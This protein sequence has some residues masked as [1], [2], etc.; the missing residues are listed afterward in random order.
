MKESNLNIFKD[1]QIKNT[2]QRSVILDILKNS[3]E[4]L[5]AE[6]MFLLAKDIDETISLSTIYRTLTLFVEKNLLI[7]MSS[8][9]ENL[10]KYSLNKADHAHY[11]IC[12]GCKEK[13]EINYC[14]LSV[15]EEKLEVTYNFEITGHKLEIF[16]YCQKCLENK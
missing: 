11:L 8:I 13:I 1:N 6:E 5:T 9:E 4:S 15:Y 2:K 16:G 3:E 14:P 12:L 7:K 10:A